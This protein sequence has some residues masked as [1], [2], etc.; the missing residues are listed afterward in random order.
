MAGPLLIRYITLSAAD[1]A[2]NMAIDEAILESHLAGTSPATLRLYQFQPPAVTIGANQQVPASLKERLAGRGFGLARRPTGGRAVLHHNDLTYSFVG[3]SRNKAG[4]SRQGFL[5]ASIAAAYR[6]ICQGLILGLA[7]VG[8]KVDLGA[9]DVPYRQHEDCF[10]ATTGSDLQHAG[11]KIAGSAQLRRRE[12]VLQHGSI[13][14]DQDQGEMKSLLALSGEPAVRHANL[15]AAAGRAVPLDELCQAIAHGFARAFAAEIFPGDLTASEIE[16]AIA[17][18][19][20]Y[21][22]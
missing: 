21:R 15:F 4:G 13:L 11:K 6:Q 10:L 20:R 9:P 14:L 3:T 16:H 18:C 22:V 17:L 8:V 19:Q 1:A 12:G 2:T 5:E 7:L